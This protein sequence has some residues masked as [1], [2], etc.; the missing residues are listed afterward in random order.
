MTIEDVLS[1]RRD[2]VASET[3]QNL[4]ATIDKYQAGIQV[5]E[6][7]LQEVQPPEE[8]REAFDD[9]VAASQDANRAVNEAE[10]YRNELQPKARAEAAEIIARA[11]AYR[12]AKIAE[13]HGESERFVALQREYRKA[14]EITRKRLY[15]EM[16]EAVLPKVETVVIE[17]GTSQVLPFLPIG[18]YTG[19]GAPAGRPAAER[20]EARPAPQPRPAQP[21]PPLLRSPSPAPTVEGGAP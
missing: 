12:E 21:P 13:S 17:Q 1:E 20:A 11:N 19:G 9:V 18:G 15:L 2:D 16:M 7:Q 6:V 10:G 4:Q 5:T 8:V 14:P 3:A